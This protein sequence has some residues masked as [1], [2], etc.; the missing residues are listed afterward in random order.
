MGIVVAPLHLDVCVVFCSDT[1]SSGDGSSSGPRLLLWIRLPWLVEAIV[2]AFPPLRMRRRFDPNGPGKFEGA[3]VMIST[4]L[5]VRQQLARC[6]YVS[7][8]VAV[9]LVFT[10]RIA[11]AIVLCV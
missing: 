2:V 4:V 7:Q 11:L 1:F 8:T 10:V 6:G 5:V 3:V 9:L